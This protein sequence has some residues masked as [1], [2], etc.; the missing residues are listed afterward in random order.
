[1]STNA[2]M[3]V[4]VAATVSLLGIL[5][6]AMA[7]PEAPAPA[8]A[9]AAPNYFAFVHSMEGTRPDGDIKLAAGDQLVV[10]AEL[11]HLFDY[12]LAGLGEKSL[13]AITAEIEKELERRLK[14]APAAAAKRLLANYLNYRRALVD[15]E[16][17]LPKTLNM[18]QAARSRLEAMQQLRQNY[19]T[20][21]E[22]AGLFGFSDAYDGDAVARLDI[23]QDKNL[24]AEQKLQKLAALDKAMPA[25]LRAERDAPGRVMR[26]EESVAQLRAQGAGDNQIYSMRAAAL[27]PDAAAR[28]ADLDRDEASWKARILAYVAERNKLLAEPEGQD[29]SVRQSALQQLRD[30]NFKPDE[31]KRLGA[32]E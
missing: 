15:I 28:L 23:S 10:D 26:I 25:A 22:I 16:G 21:A 9:R 14:P 7:K 30:A 20:A 11:G 3:M 1:M 8:P 24:S 17:D 6:Y 5:Y 31:Q 12:Y 18:A 13:D 2:K 4:G 29:A 27:S 32:Y 19:F